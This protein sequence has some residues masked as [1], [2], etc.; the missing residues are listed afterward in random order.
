MQSGF[1]ETLCVVNNLQCNRVS[2]LFLV[3]LT[4]QELAQK[5]KKQGCQIMTALNMIFKS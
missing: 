4:S 1:M 2:N 3:Q 5:E